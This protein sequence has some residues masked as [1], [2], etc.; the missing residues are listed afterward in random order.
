LAKAVIK[1]SLKPSRQT[2]PTAKPLTAAASWQP[3]ANSTPDLP[4]EPL[5]S[6]EHLTAI[7]SLY[8]ILA[9]NYPSPKSA[10][11]Q[12]EDF[13][14]SKTGRVWFLRTEGKLVANE[15]RVRLSSINAAPV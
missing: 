4:V 6:V 15:K 1:E 8:D 13:L 3:T 12:R 11:V 2:M 7:I 10:A 5:L 14:A 9:V